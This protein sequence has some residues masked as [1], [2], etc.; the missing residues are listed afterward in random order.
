MKNSHN[1]YKNENWFFD[2]LKEGCEIFEYDVMSDRKGRLYIA[3]NYKL[4][5]FRNYNGIER[6]KN[7]SYIPICKYIYIEIKTGNKKSFSYI[8]S[9]LKTLSINCTVIL[10]GDDY[11]WFS[12]MFQKR[13]ELRDELY[14][15]LKDKIDIMTIEDAKEKLKIENIDAWEY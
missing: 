14:E 2:G 11:N 13:R 12:K 6:L 10:G 9:L 7:I 8:F 5:F 15:C 1:D 3:H 4:P